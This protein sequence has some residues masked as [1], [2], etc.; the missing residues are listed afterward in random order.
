VKVNHRFEKNIYS[1]GIQEEARKQHE[2]CIN[3][4]LLPASG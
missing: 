4:M 2:A 1:S 3:Q